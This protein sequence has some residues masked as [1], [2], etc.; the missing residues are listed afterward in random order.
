MH[1]MGIVQRHTTGNQEFAV[2]LDLHRVQIHGHTAKHGFAVRHT[3]NT[4][5]TSGTRRNK[6]LPC[7]EPKARSA[8]GKHAALPCA[9]GRHTA[10]F[11]PRVPSAP[12]PNGRS[13]PSNFAVC[14]G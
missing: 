13:T 7:A 11:L 9:K 3:K 1:V 12:N 10:K 4:R 2:R 14:L 8:H 5:R 6:A